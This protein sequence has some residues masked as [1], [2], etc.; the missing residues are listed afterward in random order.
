MRH[1]K[2]KPQWQQEGPAHNYS[3]RS[4][5]QTS[6]LRKMLADV[7]KKDDKEAAG[8]HQQDAS[9]A[10]ASQ[11]RAQVTPTRGS[12][13]HPEQLQAPAPG[14]AEA[15]QGGSSGYRSPKASEAERPVAPERGNGP[16]SRRCAGRLLG[17]A[18][19]SRAQG[20]HGPKQVRV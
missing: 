16:S 8:P 11:H 1:L 19:P 10:G 4:F 18:S 14:L 2:R 13:V 6:Q 15:Y 7:L 5:A 17:A 3:P 20:H 9:A 12:W